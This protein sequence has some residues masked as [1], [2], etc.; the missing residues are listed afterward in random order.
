MGRM[1]KFASLAIKNAPRDDSDQ[2]V[3]AQTAL[4]L[5]WAHMSE[6]TFLDVATK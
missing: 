6:G 4:I 1:I 5:R 3:N 2:C